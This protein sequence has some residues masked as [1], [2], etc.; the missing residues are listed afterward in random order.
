MCFCKCLPDNDSGRICPVSRGFT[1]DWKEVRDTKTTDSWVLGL[2]LVTD[3]ILL[4]T[5]ST[6]TWN[7]NIKQ[8][9]TQQL[10]NLQFVFRGVRTPKYLHVLL[11]FSLKIRLE[12]AVLFNY[13]AHALLGQAK[14]IKW[15]NLTI[16]WLSFTCEVL[17]FHV[18][19]FA[20]FWLIHPPHSRVFL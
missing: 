4:S 8:R 7:A 1:G 15:I 13:K 20:L 6:N 2:C 17:Y 12:K 16:R 10:V 18:P 19:H 3:T 5:W 14:L 9:Y 11:S